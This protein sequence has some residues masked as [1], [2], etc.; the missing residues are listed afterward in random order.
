MT[1]GAK[2]FINSSPW[3]QVSIDGTAVGN[4]PRANVDLTAG[5]HVIRV[6]RAGY[7][8]WERAV[9]VSAGETLRITD[10]VLAPTQP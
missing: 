1:G 7:V 8:T 2:L 6:I 10:I 9:R 4:T 3:G 5:S